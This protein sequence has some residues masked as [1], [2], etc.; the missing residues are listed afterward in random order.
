MEPTWILVADGAR[1]RLFR[2]ERP[3]GPL[4]EEA[5]FV[6]PEERLPERELGSD[7]PGRAAGPGGRRQALGPDEGRRQHEAQRFAAELA[8]HLRAGREQGRF[9]RLY[10]AAAPH[11]LGA[12]R[13]ALDEHTAAL[14]V[15]SYDKDLVRH[16]ATDIREHLPYRL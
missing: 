8:H 2:V 9:R 12:L 14:I 10:L 5:D 11:F 16:D 3:R 13:R 1:A 7:D 6:H 15:E 4:I